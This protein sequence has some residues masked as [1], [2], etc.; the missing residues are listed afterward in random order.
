MEISIDHFGRIV[1]PKQVRE[2]FALVPGSQLELQET[3]DTII[4][5][6]H[7]AEP[8][9]IEKEGVLVYSGKAAGD[10]ERALERHRVERLSLAG[11]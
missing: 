2:H 4:L 1:I 5:R 7:I 9:L 6:P 10:L 8:D 11:E 3:N